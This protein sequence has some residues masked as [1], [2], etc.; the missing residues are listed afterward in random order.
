[1]AVAPTG[2]IYKTLTFDGENSADYGVYITGAAVFNSP[3][4]DVELIT[5]PGRNGDFA[6]D[7][8]R[9][10]N[11]KITYP[12][13]LFADTE[14]DFAE[15]ISA[16]RNM[17]ASRTTYCRIED[18]YNPGE[19]RMG[20][21]RSGIEVDLASLKSGEF[22]ITFECKPER[23]LTDGE[24]AV[25]V[26]DGDT[27]SNPTLFDAKPIITLEGEGSF[28]IGDQKVSVNNETLGQIVL[29]VLDT[30]FYHEGF[31]VVFDNE[32]FNN[33]D[34][35]STNAVTWPVLSVAAKSNNLR[36]IS[37][38]L[39]SWTS[40]VDSGAFVGPIIQRGPRQA[41]LQSLG[42]ENVSYY[43]NSPT[44]YSLGIVLDVAY[45]YLAQDNTEAFSS[46]TL[47][48]SFTLETSN[49]GSVLYSILSEASK[50]VK[51]TESDGTQLELRISQAIE[52]QPP[53]FYVDSSVYG[54][55]D[56]TID[57][58]TGMATANI[59]GSLTAF[60]DHVSFTNNV[61]P[62][63]APGSNTITKD[64]TITLLEIEPR[65]WK[66]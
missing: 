47:S 43:S 25:S 61:P 10:M 63:L 19:Y 52:P 42:F 53:T 29:P 18:D 66:V 50:N 39:N 41:D 55:N 46:R 58:D 4:R 14:E 5:I 9:F 3:E 32:L 64:D 40:Y 65:W 51:W 34:I 33:G 35:I 49:Y 59:G 24:T 13:G 2:G 44:S 27:L 12:C 26:S 6:L 62:R 54:F 48:L 8:G 30:G 38:S 16:F 20:L 60:N 36:T 28:S 11:I 1:M 45:S 22:E 37:V 7:K 56:L 21:Y 17:L 23:W 31:L 57:T 15:A